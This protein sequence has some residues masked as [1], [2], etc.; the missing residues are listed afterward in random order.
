[1]WWRT[2]CVWWVRGASSNPAARSSVSSWRPRDTPN[3]SRRLPHDWQSRGMVMSVDTASIG[4]YI[5]QFA[6]ARS[7]LP[8]AGFAWLDAKRDAAIKRFGSNGFPTAKVEAWKFTN[9]NPLARTVFHNISVP[10][11]PIL[12]QAALAPYRLTPDCHLLLFAHGQ[13]RP[14]LSALDHLPDGPRR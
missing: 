7:L 10:S 14:D 3:W 1:M 13:F 2:R 8:G 6:A 4:P 5:G 11:Q 9:L 12:T